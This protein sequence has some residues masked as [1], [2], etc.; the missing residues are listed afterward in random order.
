VGG[1]GNDGVIKG[2]AKDV[3]LGT[4]FRGVWPFLIACVIAV[5]I[6]MVFPDIALYI[7]TRMR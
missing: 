2:V 4:I 5:V 7:P 3:P 1:G 6:I